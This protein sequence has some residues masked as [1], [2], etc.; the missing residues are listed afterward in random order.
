MDMF[1][2]KPYDEYSQQSI[3][4]YAKKLEGKTLRLTLSDED[5]S[6]IELDC[7]KHPGNKGKLGHNVEKYYFEYELNS[8]SFTD[9]PCGLELKVTPLYVKKNREYAPK[10][11]LV[12]NIINYMEIV[13]ETWD[14]STF[15][16]K[17]RDILI[18]RYIDP[19]DKNIHLLDYEILDAH[20]HNIFSNSDDAKQF[21]KDWNIIVKKIK[22]G[23]AHLLSEG[24][25]EYLAANTKGANRESSYRK[26][27]YSDEPASQRSFSFKPKFLKKILNDQGIIRHPQAIDLKEV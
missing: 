8:S 26:Q 17:N 13:N 4:R 25:T 7:E 24:D 2:S 5:I 12:C 11:R 10:E 18:I 27:P 9:F 15:L 16:G 1:M 14:K 6:N 23:K 22:D 3:L 19:M 21:E 20:I